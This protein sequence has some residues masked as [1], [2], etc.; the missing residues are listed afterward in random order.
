MIG[1]IALISFTATIPAANWLIHNIGTVCVPAGPCL[2]PVGFSL[3]SPSGVLMIGLA[4]VLRDVVHEKLGWRWAVTAIVMGAAL[5]GFVAP[6]VFIAA[7]ISAFLFSEFADMAVYSR[8]RE[9]RL[10][11][12]V[13]LSGAV[14]AAI[15][16]AIFLQVAFGSQD[17]LLGNFVGKMWMSVLVIPIIFLVR[18]RRERRL[19]NN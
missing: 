19:I 14:G 12:A 15:D 6:P 1:Y 5:S 7:S 11:L 8:L 9:K 10:V 4:L 16:S 2:I 3:M 18:S 13:F 17:H